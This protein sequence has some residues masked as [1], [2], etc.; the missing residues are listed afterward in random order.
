MTKGRIA[1]GSQSAVDTDTTHHMSKNRHARRAPTQKSARRP[2][3]AADN[4][5]IDGLS[6]ASREPAP[7]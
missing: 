4:R 5:Q 1:L 7:Q 3:G 2:I 6:P